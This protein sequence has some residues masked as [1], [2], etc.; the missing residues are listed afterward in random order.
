VNAA[1]VGEKKGSLALIGAPAREREFAYVHKAK[2]GWQRPCLWH[3]CDGSNIFTS[4][5]FKPCWQNSM[6]Q[7]R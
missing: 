4:E 3:A 2:P 5:P 1:A 7:A 6:K